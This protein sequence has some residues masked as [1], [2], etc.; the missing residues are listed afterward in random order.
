MPPGSAAARRGCRAEANGT[1]TAL[2]GRVA[3]PTGAPAG[4]GC[5]SNVAT[6]EAGFRCKGTAIHFNRRLR[7]S[8]RG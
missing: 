1:R 2:T 3:C 5:G 7:S 4:R 8:R 6:S